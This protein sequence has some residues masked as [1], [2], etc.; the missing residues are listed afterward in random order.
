ML[1]TRIQYI[2]INTQIHKLITHP[3]NKFLSQSH[4]YP[5]HQISLARLYK[6]PQRASFSKS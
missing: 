2:N 4:Q 6:K 1:L 5:T 3:L